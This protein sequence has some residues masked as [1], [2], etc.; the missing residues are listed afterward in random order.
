MEDLYQEQILDHANSPHNKYVMKDCD[1][2]AKGNNPSC[3]DQAIL[4]FKLDQKGNITEV[5]FDGEGC[6]ISI[7]SISMLTD[8]LKNMN[9]KDLKTIM[10]GDIYKMLGINI[11]P[12]R[13]NCALLSYRALEQML[14]KIDKDNKN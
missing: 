10:P 7:A 12:A 13:V 4:Y 11:S 6:A 8:K 5:S 9:I 14:I 3:G 2:C 1:F